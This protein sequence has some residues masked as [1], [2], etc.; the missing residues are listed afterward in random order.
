MSNE[1]SFKSCSALSEEQ[2]RVYHTKTQTL[3]HASFMDGEHDAFKEHMKNTPV[4]QNFDGSL[5]QG[6]ELV[7]SKERTMSDVAPTLMVLLQNGAKLARNYL[8]MP[9]MM[10]PYHVICRSTGDH[11]QLLELM[12][13][14][15]GRTLLNAKNG[16][17]CTAL[18]YAVWNANIKCV[19]SLTVNGA[20]V[21]IINDEAKFPDIM[22]GPLIDSINLLRP[23]SSC[24]YNTMMDIF[25]LLLDSGADVNKPCF[26]E[27]RTPIMYAAMAGN[28]NCVEKLIRKGAQFNH[29]SDRTGQTLGT[30]A[31]SAG[32][33]DVLKCLSENNGID[34]NSVDEEGLS[35]LYWAVDNGNIEAVRYLLRQGETTTSYVPQECVETCSKCQTNLSCYYLD[36]IQLEIDPYMHAIKSNKSDVVRLMDE[37]GCELYKSREILS[38]AIRSESVDVVDYLLCKYKYPLNDG[39]KEQYIDGRWDTSHQNFLINACKSQSEELVK[40]LLEHGADP[41]T[42][43]CA[44][45]C[46]S[47]INV[48]IYEL[49]VE[50]IARLI[51]GGVN[52]NTRSH[53]SSIPMCSFLPFEVAIHTDH[54]YAAEMLLVSGCSRGKYRLNLRFDNN[55][56]SNANIGQ[57]MEKL[58][59]DWKVYKNNVLPLEQR[60]RMVILN[61]LCPQADK[62]IKELPLPPQLIKYL[63]I[64]ELDDIVETFR[65]KHAPEPDYY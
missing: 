13:K 2:L 51:R 9:S 47:V 18:M 34:I 40:L 43:Y 31:A 22:D 8:V 30:L 28:V 16:Y 25:D 53:Y 61:H 37:Y 4:P 60:C 63:S 33:V 11:Q 59:K 50:I 27:N 23:Y 21:N 45:E 20:D 3:L 29:G 58:L 12:I 14:E 26:N 62:K 64:P 6:I 17:G 46:P 48:A 55:P 54:I 7:M 39:Y 41:N 49:H 42:K 32:S 38:H 52:I 5:K 1:S 15:L 65:C 57:E 19:K 44:E 35:V 56:V 24:S 36:A 10:T